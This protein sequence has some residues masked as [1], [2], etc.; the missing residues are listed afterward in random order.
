MKP[1]YLHLHALLA[2]PASFNEKRNF[3][4]H[5][6]DVSDIRVLRH[7]DQYSESWRVWQPFIASGR[8]GIFDEDLTLFRVRIQGI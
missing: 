2:L 4:I 1:L 6:S 7:V 5:G 8:I 3:S